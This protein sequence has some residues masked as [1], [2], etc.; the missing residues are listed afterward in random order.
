[1]TSESWSWLPETYRNIAD[2]AGLE[3]ALK[4]GDAYG[5]RRIHSPRPARLT[6]DHWLRALIGDEA[7]E[8]L[9]KWADGSQ[10][11]LPLPPEAGV[12]GRR[13]RAEKALAD[14]LSAD[15]AARISGRHVRSV[16]RYRQRRRESDDTPDL[17]NFDPARKRLD[18]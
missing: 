4:I 3:A 5:G 2:V 6:K 8:A 11:E 7:A 17:F 15:E 14:G 9:C 16:Y 13:R 10:I 12:S 1:M 18:R